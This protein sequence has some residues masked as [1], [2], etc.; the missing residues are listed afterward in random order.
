[1]NTYICGA[2]VRLTDGIV[3]LKDILEANKMK[4]IVILKKFA[5]YDVPVRVV[6]TWDEVR[7]YCNK[8]HSKYATKREQ[9]IAG[10]YIDSECISYR[11]VE[12]KND[13][14]IKWG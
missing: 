13:K 7:D 14:P 6:E 9:D 12:F 11:A 2:R 10:G 4:C 3:G 5:M 8:R 1:M